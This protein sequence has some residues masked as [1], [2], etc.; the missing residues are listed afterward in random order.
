MGVISCVV[1]QNVDGLHQ[2]AGSEGV[3]EF[4]GDLL[5]ARCSRC[6]A[7]AGSSRALLSGPLPPLCA[8]CGG[9]V[10][11]SAT[12]FG[13]SLPPGAVAA[14][15][16]AVNKCDVLLVVGTSASVRPASELPRAAAARGA[17][18]VEVN[19][20]DT[21]L[22]NRVSHRILRGK[23]GVVL[24][25]VAARVAQLRVAQPGL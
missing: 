10:K 6:G 11:P 1:T 24:P 18:V 22:T 20:D 3:V 4:H 2:A 13:E 17:T 21:G 8:T 12:L 16:S 9:F 5:T 15:L 19:T 25:A 23:A 7:P 14:A